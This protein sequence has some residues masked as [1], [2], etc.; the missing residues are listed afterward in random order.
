MVVRNGSTRLGEGVLIMSRLL[1]ACGRARASVR[2][3]DDGT[4]L[5]NW[6]ERSTALSSWFCTFAL[7]GHVDLQQALKRKHAS[8]LQH[9]C[10][11]R[12]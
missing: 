7:H 6:F 8:C 12:A 2:A 9:Q 10:S 5:S 4:E 11:D 1:E 3:R